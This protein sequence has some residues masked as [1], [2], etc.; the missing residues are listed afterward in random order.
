MKILLF[1]VLAVAMI[2]LMVPSAFGEIDVKYE[3][4][5]TWE[6][7]DYISPSMLQGIVID[8]NDHIYVIDSNRLIKMTKDNQILWDA[9]YDITPS[10]ELFLNLND[11]ILLPFSHKGTYELRKYSPSGELLKA[12]NLNDFEN[13]FEDSFVYVDKNENIYLNQVWIYFEAEENLLDYY[14]DLGFKVINGPFSESV[15]D[16]KVFIFEMNGSEFHSKF[17]N[18]D[19]ELSGFSIEKEVF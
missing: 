19:K 14:K 17:I 5:E 4:K 2:G 8:S 11:E 12:W 3:W 16:P 9:V 6:K 15:Q 10:G 1:S 18:Y 7:L 13:S